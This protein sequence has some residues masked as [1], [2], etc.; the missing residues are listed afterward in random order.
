MRWKV[1]L[2][3]LSFL[4]SS[5]AIGS[6]LE[7]IRKA[8]KE[9]GAKWEAG[10]TSVSKLSPE[11][12][13]R[14]L[15]DNLVD[16][17]L[18][19]P[20]EEVR[21]TKSLPAEFDWRNKD[22]HFWM[23][24]IKN[25]ENC[26]ACVAFGAVGALEANL[27]IQANNFWI[28]PDLSEQHIFS[29]G[30]GPG[31]CE[32][33][34]NLRSAMFYLLDYGAPDEA[35]LPYNAVDDNCGETCSDWQARARKI[36][37]WGW[38]DPTIADI[39]SAIYNYGPVEGHF[40]VYTDF[41]NYHSGVY[42]Y[43]WGDYEGGHAIPIVGWSDS[44]LCWICK[45]SW[46]KY[47]GEY[48][49]YPDSTRGWFR[50]KYGECG[51]EER[52]ATWM[53]PIGWGRDG[54]VLQEMAYQFY[55]PPDS[56]AVDTFLVFNTHSLEF[57]FDITSYPAW[58]SPS[59]MT[60]TLS[61]RDS[62][63]VGFEVSSS[64]LGGTYA[65]TLMVEVSDST[66]APPLVLPVSVELDVNSPFKRGDVITDG[67]YTMGDGL[68][69]LSYYIYGTPTPECADALDYNDDGSITVGDGLACLSY[70]I[71]G[72]PLPAS[73][74]TQCGSDPTT[75]DPYDCI[76]HEFC[77]GGG[78]TVYK[79]PV[80]LEGAPNRIMV[81]KA[82]VSDG[83]VRIPV[84]LTVS[85][86]VPGFGISVHYD[87]SGLRFKDVVGGDGYDFYAFADEDG[88][89]KLG[90]VPDVEMENILAVGE[91]RVAEFVFEV[92]DKYAGVAFDLSDVEVYNSSIEAMLVEWV[93]KAGTSLPSEF[94]LSQN[95]PNP[96]NPTT[97]IKYELPMDCS[98][99]LDVYNVV[100]QR[101]ATLVDGYQKAGYKV[102]MWDASNNA[103]GVY[104]YKLNAGEFRSIK[105]MVLLR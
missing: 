33:G 61:E 72:T 80:S 69:I 63:Y 20:G 1:Y 88:V 74:G 82:V 78:K 54:A 4:V 66:D 10:E 22:G 30:R 38:T 44:S 2:I 47:W 70:Y 86:E 31:G 50:I 81:G 5:S 99:R 14:L 32:G 76:W 91:H 45:N 98:V 79:P 68:S 67:S 95:Y 62:V 46:G 42:E 39:K 87:V 16:D 35:C 89:V 17:F 56:F 13:R 97:L 18:K 84:D 83:L 58:L 53:V 77:M 40:Y 90:C 28:I 7:E 24:P 85:E 94:A 71:Y 105:K 43:V 37:S 41:F 75:D 6:E 12:R 19:A 57:T 101:V 60:D 64:G 59:I 25:Q 23:T 51:I 92:V 15:G 65:G 21:G 26:G 52:K 11:E 55:L 29:C 104:F 34:W 48:G 73:P 103:S 27:K 49:P 93:V 8:I 36:S 102:A 96:F 100:G 9:K 3:I